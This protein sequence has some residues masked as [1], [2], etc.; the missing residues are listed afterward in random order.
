MAD[1]VRA[2]R[3]EGVATLTLDRPR[4][5]NA[6]TP[7]LAEDLRM[8]LAE[9][10]ADDAVRV[11]RLRGAGRAFCAGYDIGWGSEWMVHAEGGRPW[12]PSLSSV[13]STASAW[14]AAPTSRC[15]AI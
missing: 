7:E 11:I 1:T 13:R 6:I 4:R 10:I 12:D 3:A 2:E 5:L 8:A 9:A 15:A 14:A